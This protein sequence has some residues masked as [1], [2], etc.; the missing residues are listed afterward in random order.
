M[1]HAHLLIKTLQIMTIYAFFKATHVI[2]YVPFKKNLIQIHI[3]EPKLC[4]FQKKG[5]FWAFLG[6][7]PI[8]M[9]CK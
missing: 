2:F 9:K 3:F 5:K 8:S 6:N 4:Y 7:V 1:L